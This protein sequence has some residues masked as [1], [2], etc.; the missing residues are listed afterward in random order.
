MPKL[1]S[2]R[3]KE[4]YAAILRMFYGFFH[5]LEKD[6]AR[7]ITPSILED[8]GSRRTA[9]LVLT[10]LKALGLR[11]YPLDL[12]THL[13]VIDSAPTALGA[14]YVLE[15]STLGGRV[16]MKML[17]RQPGTPL[18]PEHLNFFAGYGEETGPKWTAL[19]SVLNQWEHE[20]ATIVEAADQTFQCLSRWMGQT[21][22][23]GPENKL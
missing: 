13:P 8:I 7:Y 6:I 16:I 2:I 18:R 12:C 3:D 9:S 15:G 14:L 19:V 23:N 20:S 11:T 10:D 22:Y 17:L 4:E 1:G 5:P 21:L